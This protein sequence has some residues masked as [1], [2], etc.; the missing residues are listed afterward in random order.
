MKNLPK[1]LEMMLV[2]AVVVVV[3]RTIASTTANLLPTRLSSSVVILI[4]NEIA[5][6]VLNTIILLVTVLGFVSVLHER[7][8]GKETLIANTIARVSLHQ[9]CRRLNNSARVHVVVVVVVAV[10]L[11]VMTQPVVLPIVQT[12]LPTHA[13]MPLSQ[14]SQLLLQLNLKYLLQLASL[15]RLALI[16][17]SGGRLAK[18][19][20]KVAVT[21]VGHIHAALLFPIRRPDTFARNIRRTTA[22]KLYTLLLNALDVIQ[23][24]GVDKIVD[25]LAV[26]GRLVEGR[27]QVLDHLDSAACRVAAA[28]AVARR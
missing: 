7:T 2:L 5:L 14:L 20:S 22:V 25:L 8:E 21:L 27:A 11:Y 3:R 19:G 26:G 12:E 24:L 17:F 23:K 18:L 15:C 10:S 13:H 9:A 16:A 6:R 28:A 1:R 4:R